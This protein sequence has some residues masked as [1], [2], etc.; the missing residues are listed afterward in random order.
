[1]RL[2]DTPEMEK[3]YSIF[4]PFLTHKPT[5]DPFISGTPKE[6]KE[7]FEKYSRLHKEQRKRVVSEFFA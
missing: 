5:D 3:L 6:A 2:I 4:A 7:A 1:M